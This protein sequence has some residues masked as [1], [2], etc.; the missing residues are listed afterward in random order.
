LANEITD[1]SSVDVF[2]LL[3]SAGIVTTAI[4]LIS[5]GIFV[6]L[7]IKS[8]TVKSFQSQISIFISVYVAGEL[9]ELAP[10]QSIT[11][12]PPE[13]GSQIHLGATLVITTIM[14]SRLFYSNE[15]VKKLVDP[16]Q[17]PTQD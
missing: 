13:L 15:I 2:S 16:P 9:L 6:L 12:L 10:I 14:W 11:G 4:F 8:K 17:E 7:A 1:T 3:L 5:L